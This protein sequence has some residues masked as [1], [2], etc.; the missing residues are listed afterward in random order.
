MV[1]F[2][3]AHSARSAPWKLESNTHTHP[4]TNTFEMNWKRFKLA[5]EMISRRYQ[6]IFVI[7]CVIR[8]DWIRSF[9]M[10]AWS[11][12]PFHH[13]N[14]MV[15]ICNLEVSSYELTIWWAIKAT[16]H[17]YATF[18]IIFIECLSWRFWSQFNL[19]SW[20]D[21][22]LGPGPWM[23]LIYSSFV[24]VSKRWIVSSNL[25]YCKIVFIEDRESAG[26][27]KKLN[28]NVTTQPVYT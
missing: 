14:G 22:L 16:V 9:N 10:Q 17:R 23:L 28:I 27:D 1:C 19:S 13:S 15:L 25:I 8:F 21:S 7:L 20:C 11:V 6:L 26:I 4:I 24:V 3:F 18:I 2:C 12:V 5:N